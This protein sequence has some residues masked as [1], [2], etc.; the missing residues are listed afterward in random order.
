MKDGGYLFKNNYTI[1]I[2]NIR[3]QEKSCILIPEGNDNLT[4]EANKLQALLH[5][6][7]LIDTYQFNRYRQGEN[8]GDD[9][10]A[11]LIILGQDE[12]DS[13]RFDGYADFISRYDYP[14][15]P[16]GDGTVLQIEPYDRENQH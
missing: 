8:N 15:M 14:Q 10:N 12:I 6:P 3:N 1:D 7:V 5:Y 4:I 13:S 2:G 9:T 16:Y 11:V